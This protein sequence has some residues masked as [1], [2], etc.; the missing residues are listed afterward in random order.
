MRRFETGVERCTFV[1]FGFVQMRMHGDMGVAVKLGRGTADDRKP[2]IVAQ[3]AQP[4]HGFKGHRATF[5]KPV[6][7][8]NQKVYRRTLPKVGWRVGWA[9]V[10]NIGARGHDKRTLGVKAIKRIG[11]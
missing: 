8:Q 3:G 6:A 5:G 4:L 2:R 10:G 11:L 7:P 1:G 9:G